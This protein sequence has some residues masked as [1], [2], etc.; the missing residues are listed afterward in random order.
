MKTTIQ[1][2]KASAPANV[3]PSSVPKTRQLAFVAHC[4]NRQLATRTVL[5][6]LRAQLPGQYELAEIVG[7]L[8]RLEFSAVSHRAAANTRWRLGFH[9]NQRRCVWQHPCGAGTPYNNIHS[10]DPRAKYSSRFAA[11]AALP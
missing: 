5:K 1:S 11:E 8:I 6:L 9:W 2:I 7:K 3:R 10:D 4:A